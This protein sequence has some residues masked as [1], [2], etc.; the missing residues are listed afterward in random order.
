MAGITEVTNVTM[1][2]I[3]E[4]ANSSTLP[5]FMIKLNHDV[6]GGWFW[7]VILLSLWFVLFIVAQ[8]TKDQPLNNV[9]YSGAVV[10][11]AALLLRG[12]TISRNGMIQGM[13][14]DHQLWIF[15]LITIVIAIIVWATKD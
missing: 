8:K 7:F 1:A 5:E 12:I 10:S 6:Y 14:T 3:Q 13:I 9:M 2:Q 11:I 15:P 4:I